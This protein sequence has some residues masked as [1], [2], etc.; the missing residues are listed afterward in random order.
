MWTRLNQCLAKTY[1]PSC[2][3]LFAISGILS[4]V[5]LFSPPIHAGTSWWSDWAV[6]DSSTP[7]I[8]VLLACS[9]HHTAAGEALQGRRNNWGTR[10]LPCLSKDTNWLCEGEE[11]K[12]GLPVT[13]MCRDLP[14]S[15]GGNS[16]VWPSAGT[17]DRLAKAREEM[18]L[19][20]HG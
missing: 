8:C 6:Q 13:T 4:C 20:F 14:T 11:K 9:T 7:A 18:F 5:C 2:L 15:W 1:R 12:Q 19:F 10:E 16:G 17:G 3:K